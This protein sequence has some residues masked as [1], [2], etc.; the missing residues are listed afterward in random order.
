MVYSTG[1][2][3][4]A[5]VI[6]N[7]VQIFGLWIVIA[8]VVSTFLSNLSIILIKCFLSFLIIPLVYLCPTSIHHIGELYEFYFI[9]V[10]W[11]LTPWKPE[12]LQSSDTTATSYLYKIE[13]ILIAT[14]IISAR[15]HY[16]MKPSGACKTIKSLKM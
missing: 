12:S 2:H 10:A 7:L 9:I 6:V 16:N 1:N 14:V 8:I 5:C 4:K 11:P 15:I 3:I 13:Q